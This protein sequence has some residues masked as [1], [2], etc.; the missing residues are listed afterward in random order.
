MGRS[1]ECGICIL[2][3]TVMPLCLVQQFIV[4][5]YRNSEALALE[6]GKCK[7]VDCE[8]RLPAGCD[9]AIEGGPR[10]SGLEWLGMILLP[11]CAPSHKYSS[12]ILER[13]MIVHGIPTIL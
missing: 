12:C 10:P 3:H 5:Q 7:H 11:I 13:R 6:K 1:A 2:E 8:D 9:A 4:K